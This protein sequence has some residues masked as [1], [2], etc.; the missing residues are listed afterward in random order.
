MRCE[1]PAPPAP[2]RH[3]RLPP[4]PPPDT[5]GDGIPDASDACPNKGDQGYGIDGTGCPNIP[6]M[7]TNLNDLSLSGTYASHG[8]VKLKWAV[9]VRASWFHGGLMDMTWTDWVNAD[10]S[11]NP[12][13]VITGTGGIYHNPVVGGV[14]TWSWSSTSGAPVKWTVTCET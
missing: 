14:A 5:D 3:P 6:D 11:T 10:G 8:P 7:C 2:H 1:R 12:D 4:P 13:Q 9:G